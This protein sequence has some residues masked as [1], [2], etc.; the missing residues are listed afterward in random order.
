M[1]NLFVILV[2]FIGLFAGKR[3]GALFGVIFG[4][5]LDSIIGKSIGPN[6]IL[7]CIVGLIGEYFDKNFSKNS[8]ISLIIICA[9]ST[10][11]FEVGYYAISCIRDNV[12]ADVLR[13]ISI[14]FVE[15]IYNSI[16]MVI[17]YPFIKKVGYYIENTFKGKKL[18]TRYF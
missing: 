12:S 10:L 14:L 5:F 9:I 6:T 4:F 7:L 17:L 1:P 11:T 15:I 18:L 8:M 2:L 16:L 13:F 3:M